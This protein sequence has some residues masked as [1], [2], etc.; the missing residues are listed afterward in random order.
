M[1]KEMDSFVLFQFYS[2]TLKW[3]SINLIFVGDKKRNLGYFK[4]VLD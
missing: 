3:Y 2:S 4:M 1:I